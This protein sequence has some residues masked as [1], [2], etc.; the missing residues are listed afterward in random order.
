MLLDIELNMC[1]RKVIVYNKKNGERFTGVDIFLHA[2]L[3]L[4]CFFFR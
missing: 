1:A 3:D 2:W 4:K